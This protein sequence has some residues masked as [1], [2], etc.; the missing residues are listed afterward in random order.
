MPVKVFRITNRISNRVPYV[1]I[2]LVFI[3]VFLEK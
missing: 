3:F 2:E 1:L